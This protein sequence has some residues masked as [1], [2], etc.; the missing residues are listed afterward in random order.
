MKTET[1]QELNRLEEENAGTLERVRKV[2]ETALGEDWYN[3]YRIA[4]I[5]DYGLGIAEPGYW[6]EGPVWILG[7]WNP[8]R[9]RQHEGEP[10]ITEW[11][12]IPTRL[13]EIFE[14]IGVFTGWLD[15]WARC[16]DCLR[17]FRIEPNSYSWKKFGLVTEEG[18][19]LCGDCVT[20]DN[21]EPSYVNNP[22]LAITFD[23]D[24]SEEGYEPFNGRFESGWHPGQND[25]PKE[26]LERALTYWEEGIFKIDS[27]GQFD[28]SFSLWVR[29]SKEEETE[30]ETEEEE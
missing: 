18:S 19:V 30:E 8:K 27:T 15:E 24:L 9:F 10:A 23:I 3:Q 20:Y 11:E 6:G 12:M 2:L 29:N 16:D 21:I 1:A 4:E 13:A 5:T 28:I 7:N 25:N 26:I 17:I 22:D 14:R